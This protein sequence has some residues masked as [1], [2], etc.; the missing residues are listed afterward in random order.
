MRSRV[1]LVAILLTLV[2]VIHMLES[3]RPGG[4]QGGQKEHALGKKI[5]KDVQNKI[6]PQNEGFL[7]EDKTKAAKAQR[8]NNEL[9]L[10]KTYAQKRG[11]MQWDISKV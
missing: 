1:N 6:A 4:K 7:R 3:S 10:T 9:A 2:C 8:K 11:N 5:L